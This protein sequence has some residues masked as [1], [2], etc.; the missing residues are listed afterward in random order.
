MSE[1]AYDDIKTFYA[2]MAH[3]IEQGTASQ[4][5]INNFPTD[6]MTLFKLVR[7]HF[8][9]DFA[10]KVLHQI[11]E[12]IYDILYASANP[13]QAD[14]F[15]KKKKTKSAKKPKHIPEIVKDINTL[16]VRE[17]REFMKKNG[18]SGISK[19][20][21]ELKRIVSEFFDKE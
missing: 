20:K 17:L 19:P 9:P 14:R 16:T 10:L 13:K 18:L 15:P 7:F 3:Q 5:D 11:S 12:M 4:E 8:A 2:D 21:A 1:E 6:I